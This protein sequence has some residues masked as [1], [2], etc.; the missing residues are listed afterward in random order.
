MRYGTFHLP[1]LIKTIDTEE[2]NIIVYGIDSLWSDPESV[3]LGDMH[4]TCNADG[5]L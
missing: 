4:D 3:F 2:T 1:Q 5:T